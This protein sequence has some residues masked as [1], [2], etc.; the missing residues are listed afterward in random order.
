MDPETL[1]CLII[2]GPGMTSSEA[3]DA[4]MSLG[5]DEIPAIIFDMS[6]SDSVFG[7]PKHINVGSIIVAGNP[8]ISMRGL[9]DMHPLVPIAVVGENTED[10]PVSD[11]VYVEDWAKAVTAIEEEMSASSATLDQ[12]VLPADFASAHA[13]EAIPDKPVVRDRLA[14]ARASDLIPLDRRATA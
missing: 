10:D 14:T 3:L 13:I 9:R 4:S 12:L 11:I 2:R 8:D 6:S 1:Y 7:V 5:L